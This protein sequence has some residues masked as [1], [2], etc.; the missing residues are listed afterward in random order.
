MAGEPTPQTPAPTP[1]AP[2]PTET[3]IN[4]ALPETTEP[5][6]EAVEIDLD[7]GA[8]PTPAPAAAAVQPSVAPTAATPAEPPPGLKL[9]AG[10]SNNT[11]QQLR[12]QLHERDQQLAQRDSAFQEVMR[13]VNDL[14]ARERQMSITAFHHM[15]R[16]Y[17]AEDKLARYELQQAVESGD[18]KLIAQAQANLSAVQANIVQVEN[19]KRANP[20]AFQAQPTQPQQQPPQRPAQ[21]SP[22]QPQ[23]PQQTQQNPATTAWIQANPWFNPEH[24]DFDAEMHTAAAQYAARLERRWQAQGRA[25]EIATPAYF[26]EVETYMQR[27]FPDEFE[28]AAAAPP[29]ARNGGAPTAPPARTPPPGAP[30]GGSGRKVHLT[31][32]ERQM[33]RQ[34][35]RNGAIMHPTGRRMTDTEA[36]VYFAKHKAAEAAK[37]N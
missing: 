1:S 35:A 5:V 2:P 8:E 22:Q 6:P 10:R 23:G 26:K 33:A 24:D 13:G 36:E 9:K 18:A 30:Q 31:G 34:M 14:S 4:G 19:F 27:E 12:Q 37:G 32:E 21:P 7:G 3:H 15:E 28:A 29:P 17:R 25:A 11:I 20:Q 16:G